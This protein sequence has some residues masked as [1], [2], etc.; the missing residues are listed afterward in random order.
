MLLKGGD[1][2]TMSR[3]KRHSRP[4]VMLDRAMLNSAEWKALSHS[5][6]IVYTYIKRNFNGSNNGEIPLK[7]TELKG[8][9]APATISKALKGLEA[10]DWIE[11]TQYGGLHRYYCKYKLTGRY[12]NAI[13]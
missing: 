5:E 13:R 9:M 1:D 7:Y 8:I 6:M 2:V 11:K 4:F 3:H 12:D 10:N